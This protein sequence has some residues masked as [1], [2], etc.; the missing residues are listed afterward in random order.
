M[1]K[2]FEMVAKLSDIPEGQSRVFEVNKKMVSLCKVEGQI[3]AIA[4]LCSH[5]EGPLEE[6]ELNGTEIECPRHGARFDI[7]TGKALCLPAITPIPVYSVEIRS[8]EI[9]VSNESQS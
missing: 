7:K 1:T 3:F 8:D 9:W 2:T 5:D 6:G 4:D